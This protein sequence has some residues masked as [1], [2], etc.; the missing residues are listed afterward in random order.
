MIMKTCVRSL[1]S[2]AF[3]ATLLAAGSLFAAGIEGMQ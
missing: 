3:I 1:A 2:F